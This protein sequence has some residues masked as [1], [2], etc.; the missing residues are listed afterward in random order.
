MEAVVGIH[1]ASAGVPVWLRRHCDKCPATWQCAGLAAAPFSDHIPGLLPQGRRITCRCLDLCVSVKDDRRDDVHQDQDHD[2][3]E[4]QG[5]QDS[6][7]PSRLVH[8]VLVAIEQEPQQEQKCRVQCATCSAERLH[9]PTKDG[10]RNQCEGEEEEAKHD[11]KV[12]K[13][14]G[15]PLQ[16]LQHEVQ[17]GVGPESPEEAQAQHPRKDRG[18]PPQIRLPLAQARCLLQG[19]IE[20]LNVARPTQL[21]RVEDQ[22]LQLTLRVRPRLLRHRQATRN[23]QEPLREVV[24][25]E[26]HGGEEYSHE[27][28]DPVD[29]T[30]NPAVRT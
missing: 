19:G 17:P 27:E 1:G 25:I 14:G 4:G 16:R 15:R 30:P 13:V 3:L 5:P 23:I 26:V 24:A 12:R 29:G 11:R 6:Q 9:L 7:G 10:V 20:L 2:E 8:L 21:C 18:I 28:Y 22:L